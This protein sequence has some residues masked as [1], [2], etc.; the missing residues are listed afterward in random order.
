M[1]EPPGEQ[2]GGVTA[3]AQD[4]CRYG[5]SVRMRRKKWEKL[6]FADCHLPTSLHNRSHL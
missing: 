3:P 6:Q 1:F 5:G 2:S 4:G